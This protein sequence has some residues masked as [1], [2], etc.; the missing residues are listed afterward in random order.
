MSE[1]IVH[2]ATAIGSVAVHDRGNSGGETIPFWPALFTSST[3]YDDQVTFFGNHY[4]LLLIDPPGVGASVDPETLLPMEDCATAAIEILDHF[5][6]AKAH[7]V[8]TSWGGI[9][10]AILGRTAPQRFKSVALCNT[11]FDHG[12]AEGLS[13]AR[14]IIRLARIFGSSSIFANGVAKS[15]FAAG[16]PKNTPARRR[17]RRDFRGRSRKALT[18]TGRSVLIDRQSLLPDLSEI[19]VPTL[20]IAGALD[21]LYPSSHLRFAAERIAGARFV[22]LANSGHVSACE[23]PA[24]FNALLNDW[25]YQCADSDG[26]GHGL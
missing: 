13:S 16:T 26:K 5:G 22:E 2:V 9:I 24:A 3:L 19:K 11:P 12:S 20:V 14:T 21:T 6:V 15:F 23:V 8:G 4:R 17:F 7:L 1:T 18:L 10:G 25:L